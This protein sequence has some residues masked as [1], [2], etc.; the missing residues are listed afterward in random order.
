MNDYFA[1][2]APYALGLMAVAA[3]WLIARV[4]RWRQTQTDGAAGWFQAENMPKELRRSQIVMNEQTISMLQPVALQGKV[5]QVYLS[6][7][8]VLILVD[9]KTRD[10]HRVYYSDI[11]Q[12][13][14]Y[15]MILAHTTGRRVSNRGYI[16]TVLRNEVSRVV[17]FHPVRLLPDNVIIRAIK[18]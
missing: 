14:M 5:D 7:A 16:R 6:P 18:G 12:I 13:S 17:R 9:S 10:R 3:P 8:G 15:A 11:M 1:V 2:S 4:D